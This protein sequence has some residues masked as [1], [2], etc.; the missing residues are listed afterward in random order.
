[1]ANKEVSS[2]LVI[3]DMLN[4]FCPGGALPVKDGD[5]VV[6]PINHASEEIRSEGGIVLAVSERHPEETSH[7]LPKGPWPPHGIAGTWGA[8]YHP[9]LNLDGVVE[10]F[11]GMGNDEDAYSGFHGR[12]RGGLRLHPYLQRRGISRLYVV[13]LAADYCVKDTALD[14]RRYGYDVV[15]LT[16]ATKPVNIKPGD[17]DNAE[18]LM[19]ANG[20]RRA[21][22]HQLFGSY[23]K[24]G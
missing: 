22:V 19:A 18:L 9:A 7:F 13:G 3:I 5:K 8:E 12:T 15:L 14:G 10:F 21:T 4:D 6:T 1:M 2:A 23:S 16:D 24:A 20:V 11:K 17:G